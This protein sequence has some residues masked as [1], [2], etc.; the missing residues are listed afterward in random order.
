MT[1]APLVVVG[2]VAAAFV[3]WV[4]IRRWYRR[5]DARRL[6]RARAM[7]GDVDV[8]SPDYESTLAI[9]VAAPAAVVWDA[10]LRF[11]WPR[12]GRRGYE[13][14]GRALGFLQPVSGRDDQSADA[15][16]LFVGRHS[17]IPIRSVAP[18]RA[19]VLGGD[20]GTR[21]WAWQFE[22]NPLDERRTRLILRDRA[23]AERIPAWLMLAAPRALSFVLTRK[24]LLDIKTS[25]E[26]TPR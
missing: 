10:L 5:S 13:W 4:A 11:G 18:A 15:R 19:L 12:E 16:S 9:S 7:S 17:R 6:D 25:A 26:A 14:L 8:I 23:R 24:M 21:A 3:C 22:L 20:T 1:T 2:L